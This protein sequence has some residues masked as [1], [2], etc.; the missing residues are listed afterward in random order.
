MFALV[1]AGAVGLGPAPAWAAP[2]DLKMTLTGPANVVAGS[3]VAYKMTVHAGTAPDAAKVRAWMYLQ[4]QVTFGT[5]PQGADDSGPCVEGS[6]TV[7]KAD[8]IAKGVFTWTVWIKFD[9]SVQPRPLGALR[10]TAESPGEEATPADNV[11]ELEVA[12]ILPFDVEISASEVAD[13]LTAGEPVK[14]GLVVRNL[15]FNTVTDL[16]VRYRRMGA[17]FTGGTIEVEGAKCVADPG[18]M[19][20]DVPLDLKKDEFVQLPH[21]FPT[22]AD[23]NTWGKTGRIQITVDDGNPNNSDELVNFRFAPKPGSSAS[24]T[25][26]VTATAAPGTG[27]GDGGLPITGAATMPLILG[28]IVLLL[29][30]A[31]ALW[32][33]RRRSFRS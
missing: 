21:V 30:G 6:C 22:H 12:G 23:K 33:G 9:E 28:G 19:V 27:G 18:E 31:G 32:F 29:A 2:I 17:W 25:P 14:F 8:D 5:G 16:T 4:S 26:T 1:V 13:P 11:D 15:G 3:T 7:T 10:A 24:P 20:C